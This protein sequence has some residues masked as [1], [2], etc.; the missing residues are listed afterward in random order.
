M[1]GEHHW[2]KHDT[3]DEFFLVLD[4]QLLID[5]EDRDTVVLG[6]HGA[7][8]VPKG[9]LHRTRAQERGIVLVIEPATAPSAGD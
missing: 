9:V 4:G 7:Y 1:K 2:H 3:S 6:H 5:F 8:T